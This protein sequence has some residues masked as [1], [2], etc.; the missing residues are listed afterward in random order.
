[1][2]ISLGTITWKAESKCMCM[3]TSTK[4]RYNTTINSQL[5]TPISII[6]N[7]WSILFHTLY[8]STPT[9]LFK[10]KS[11]T[12]FVPVKSSVSIFIKVDILAEFLSFVH[13]F[14]FFFFRAY[15]SSQA[16]GQIRASAAGLCHNHSN[17]GSELCLQPT[18]QFMVTPEPQPTDWGQGLNMHPHGY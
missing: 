16:G 11:Q 1:M 5:P 4:I 14:F 6:I 12:S 2:K 8:S 17:L 10:S 3:L 9:R 7:K 13:A 15:G 18:P